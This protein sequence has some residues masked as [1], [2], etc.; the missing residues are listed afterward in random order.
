MESLQ[1]NSKVCTNKVAFPRFVLNKQKT[2]VCGVKFT[3][4]NTVVSLHKIGEY[5]VFIYEKAVLELLTNDLSI[6]TAM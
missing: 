3:Y 6:Y 2:V 5:V 1:G 4:I